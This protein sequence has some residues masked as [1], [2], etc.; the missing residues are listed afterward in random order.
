MSRSAPWIGLVA[1]VAAL[2]PVQAFHSGGVGSCGGCHVTHAGAAPGGPAL[3]NGSNPTD[4]CLR[5]HATANGNSWGADPALPGPQ[6]GGGAFAFLLEDNLNDGPGGAQ[7]TN[8][9][10]GAKAGHSVISIERGTPADIEHVTAPGGTYAAVSLHCT[11][12]HDPHGKSGN[13]RLLRGAGP[14]SVAGYAFTFTQAAP[15]A[16]G[17][18]L[19]GAPESDTHHNAYRSGVSTWCSNCHGGYHA[20][21][22]ASFVHPVD[23]PLGATEIDT[24]NRYRGTGYLDGTG[25]DAYVA[26]VPLAFPGNST[27]FAGPVPVDARITCLTCHRAHASSAPGSLRWDNRIATWAEEGLAS[28]SYRIPNPYE[29]TAGPGQGRLC[30]KCHGAP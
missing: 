4:V 26:P 15:D 10:P 16:S 8:W 27:G 7:P 17:I 3:L 1:V 30:E 2:G 21:G 13:Y 5:C 22:S 14:A 6:Y 25:A 20:E 12:C 29:S 24:Y 23:R 18:P 11:S 9:I 28:G 19:D